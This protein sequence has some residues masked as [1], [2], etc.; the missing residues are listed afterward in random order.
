MVTFIVFVVLFTAAFGRLFCGW[1]CPQTIFMEMFFRR[2]EY[3]IEGN[4]AEQRLLAQ[5]PWT[6]TKIAK[7]T[8]KHVV[9]Y[10]A[11]FVIANFFLS[12]I[13][14]MRE[15]WKIIIEPI[16][17]HVGGLITIVV[18]SGVFYAVYAYFREQAC[19]VV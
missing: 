12:Y 2:I 4:A 19:T 15:L 10:F 8:F 5:A 9:F 13:I 18:F 14:G 16:S 11:S 1:V 6:P 3:L 7:K 17:M